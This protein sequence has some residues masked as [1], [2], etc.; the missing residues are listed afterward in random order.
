[1]RDGRIMQTIVDFFLGPWFS[2]ILIVAFC[3]LGYFFPKLKVLIFYLFPI[4][5]FGIV[6]YLS[7]HV[8]LEWFGCGCVPITQQN[9]L[10]IPI[11]TNHILKAYYLFSFAIL[12]YFAVRYSKKLK[13]NSSIFLISVLFVNALLIVYFLTMLQ[14]Q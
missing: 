11:N 2:L 1:M 8:L 6:R 3:L 13:Q 9:R 5:T 10:G 14:F 12:F 7:S 4:L